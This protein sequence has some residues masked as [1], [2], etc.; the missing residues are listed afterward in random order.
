M[1]GLSGLGDIARKVGYRWVISSSGTRMGIIVIEPF[2]LSAARALVHGGKVCVEIADSR[3]V[4]GSLRAAELSEGLGIICHIGDYDEHLH[5]LSNARYSAA[6][7]AIRGVA[8]RSTAGLSARLI[9]S[10]VLSMAPVR[11]NSCTKYSDSQRLFRQRQ[12]HRKLVSALST[13][14]CLAI[15]AASGAWA[16]R[17]R[18]ISAASSLTRC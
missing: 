7:S 6:V 18:R 9:K 15:C 13:L 17:N 1:T 2:A 14:A 16:D 8:I 11:L 10:T 5:I 12:T 3:G 4:P